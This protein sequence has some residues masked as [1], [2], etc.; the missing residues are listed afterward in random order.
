MDERKMNEIQTEITT[1]VI[2]ILYNAI[3]RNNLDKHLIAVCNMCIKHFDINKEDLDILL[4]KN[5][6]LPETAE[7]NDLLKKNPKAIIYT[8]DKARKESFD[9][10]L[11]TLFHSKTI[12]QTSALVSQELK[13][14]LFFS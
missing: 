11:V 6:S 4:D 9:A 5:E 8:L 1:N 3:E 14:K 13:L 7:F 2:S 10:F 12:V